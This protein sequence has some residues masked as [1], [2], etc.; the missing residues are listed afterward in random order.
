MTL[1]H[2]EPRSPPITFAAS[3]CYDLIRPQR[4]ERARCGC[5]VALETVAKMRRHDPNLS[6]RRDLDVFDPYIGPRGGASRLARLLGASAKRQVGRAR[7]AGAVAGER[8]E[9]RVADP[10]RHRLRRAGDRGGP[11][12]SLREIR[13]CR[14]ADVLRCPIGRGVVEV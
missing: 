8:A 5:S 14:P 7:A 4:P 3:S 9:S 12:V 10:D 2:L 6:V 1:V 13:Q 11:T